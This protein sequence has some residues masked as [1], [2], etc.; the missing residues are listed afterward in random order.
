[1]TPHDDLG[2]RLAAAARTGPQPP[3]DLAAR[4]LRAT[5]AAG[6]IHAP[7]PFPSQRWVWIGGSM[8]AAAAATLVLL[9]LPRQTTVQPTDTEPIA[10]PHTLP[11]VPLLLDT[12]AAPHLVASALD[13]GL[14][15]EWH[16]LNADSTAIGTF[17][18]RCLPVTLD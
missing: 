12:D 17:L 7:L 6:P 10:A 2:R 11:S 13:A 18:V 8:A 1:M 3:A 16:R 4:V 15:D 14:R 5:A 9:I